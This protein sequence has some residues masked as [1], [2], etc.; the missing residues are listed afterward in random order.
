MISIFILNFSEEYA[1]EQPEQNKFQVWRLLHHVIETEMQLK[2]TNIFNKFDLINYWKSK[3]HKTFLLLLFIF[4]L[5]TFYLVFN[6][7]FIGLS[8]IPST[9]NLWCLT[10]EAFF[11][12]T[13]K[14]LKNLP[15]IFIK[16]LHIMCLI[17][18]HILIHW[19]ARCNCKLCYIFQGFSHIIDEHSGLKCKYLHQTFTDCMSDEC[20]HFDM[21]I[22]QI[23]LQ[24]MVGS[25]IQ[26]CFS[27]IYIYY[28]M[29]KTLYNFTKLLQIVC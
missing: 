7:N 19:Y 16:L 20:T 29:F 11:W 5:L 8:M 4:I 15:D 24:V 1:D 12:N 9:G 18:T 2:A 27:G 22:C 17:S 3:T 28:N 23:W 10:I 6:F 25:Q 14:F 13:L 26:L 21:S